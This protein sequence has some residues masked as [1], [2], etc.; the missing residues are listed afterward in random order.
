MA[1][2]HARGTEQ[3]GAAIADV[4]TMLELRDDII[5]VGLDFQVGVGGGR[6]SSNSLTC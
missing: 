1:Y 3:V 4:V 5:E 6:L 2:G